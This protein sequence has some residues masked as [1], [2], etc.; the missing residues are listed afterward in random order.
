MMPMMSEYENKNSQQ[1]KMNRYDIV[2]DVFF[3]FFS[4]NPR[5]K[6]REKNYETQNKR[7]MWKNV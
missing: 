3:F 5:N 4:L 2:N 7:K 6:Q 1:K